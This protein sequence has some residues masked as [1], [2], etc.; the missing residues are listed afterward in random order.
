MYPKTGRSHQ[1]RLHMQQIGHPIIGDPF[2][3]ANYSEQTTPTM[4]LHARELSFR[5]PTTDERMDIVSPPPF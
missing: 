4:Q 3:S 1:L 2:Y 5:H